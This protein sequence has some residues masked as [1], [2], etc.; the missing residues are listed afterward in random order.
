VL[1]HDHS[2]FDP[3]RAISV[4]PWVAEL[5]KQDLFSIVI[6][7]YSLTAA[8][9]MGIYA[10]WKTKLTYKVI[11]YLN[12]PGEIFNSA[13]TGT[14]YLLIIIFLLLQPA[15]SWHTGDFFI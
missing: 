8:G 7:G 14:F 12:H 6:I 5:D 13:E 10:E 4:E 1:Y 9:E 15:P 2:I 11:K 3:G